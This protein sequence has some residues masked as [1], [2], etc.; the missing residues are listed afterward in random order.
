MSDN[1]ELFAGRRKEFLERMDGGIAIFPAGPVCMRSRDVEFEYRQDSDLYYLTGFEEPESICVLNPGDKEAPYS[2]FV[3]PRDKERETWT[4]LRAGVEGAVKEYGAD[5]A[6]LIQD[7]ERILTE[8]MKNVPRIYYTVN[9]Y[10]ET[11]RMIFSILKALRRMAWLGVQPPPEIIDLSQILW[12]MRLIKKPQ[13]L[14]LLQRAVD[15]STLGHIAAME[16]TRA[17]M[18]EF[19]VQAILEY[20]FRKNGSRRNAYPTIVGSGPN[21]CILHY[22]KNDRMLRDGDLLLI[23]AAAEYGYFSADITRTF[24]VNG[25]FTP[26]QKAVYELVLH[27]Q[28]EAIARIRPGRTIGEVHE[29]A[30]RTLTAG[31]ME[32]GLLSGSLEEN[33]EN[34]SYERYYMH[35]TGHWLGMDAH[36]VGRYRVGDSW[37]PLEKG[38]VF[39]V[40]PGLYVGNEDENERFRNIGVR[41][42]DDI[43]VT[44]EGCCVLSAGCPKEVCDVEGI[45][46]KEPAF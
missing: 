35:R 7:A 36:D 34:K 26:Q 14:D 3:L 8:M 15:I 5:R 43:L 37:R 41:I 2:L 40:E 33:I 46:G 38:M 23:D 17:G 42:E 4:G 32:L 29:T 39:T 6:F 13:D 20:T 19:Q 9:K 16:H 22:V 25:R 44:E 31:I 12:D 1:P 45:V 18:Y 28:K 10:P 21:G 24:P 11:D 27:A 30:V